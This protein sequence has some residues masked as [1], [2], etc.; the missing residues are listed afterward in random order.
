MVLVTASFG[1]DFSLL[2]IIDFKKQSAPP[3]SDASNVH[4][5]VLQ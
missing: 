3:T 5:G 2:A 4:Q 1:T